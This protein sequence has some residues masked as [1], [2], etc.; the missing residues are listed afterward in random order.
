MKELKELKELK[1]FFTDTSFFKSFNQFTELPFIIYHDYIKDTIFELKNHHLILSK[2]DFISDWYQYYK[3]IRHNF[4]FVKDEMV[5]F[6]GYY[7]LIYAAFPIRRPDKI[8]IG[9]FIF[10][11]FRS[12]T[13]HDRILDL[14]HFP[15][16]D[17]LDIENRCLKIYHHISKHLQN[18]T[19]YFSIQT[20]I[21]KQLKN[22]PTLVEISKSLKINQKKIKDEIFKQTGLSFSKFVFKLKFD[23]ACQ[24]L[25]H[26]EKT[27]ECISDNLGFM[28]SPSFIR[29]FKSQTSLSPLNFRKKYKN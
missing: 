15:I 8:L 24:Q 11:G 25:I 27:I 19:L 10:G 3:K 23:F 22:K 20:E 2:T 6:R 9:T 26:T 7:N 18:K 1:E 21:Y 12:K 29:F 16:F 5:L 14:H 4:F 13:S 17:N 28:N